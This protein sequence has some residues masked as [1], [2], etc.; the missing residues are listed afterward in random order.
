MRQQLLAFLVSFSVFFSTMLL[1]DELKLKA[2]APSLYLVKSGDTLWD[3][4]GLYLQHPWLWPRLWKL[5]PQVS[6]PHLI[7]PGDELHL[8]FDADG[9]PILSL[10]SQREA[11]SRAGT[12]QV[13]N[14]STT[15]A[16]I[17]L[18]PKVRRMAKADKAIPAVALA[19]ID[20]FLSE[21]HLLAAEQ[22]ESLPYVL[23]GKENV[24]NAVSGHLLYVQGELDQTLR[25]GIYRQGEVYE[26]P[27]SG[28]ILGYEAVLMAEAKVLPP[29]MV[30]EQHISRIEVQKSRREVKQGDRL[31]PLPSQSVYPDFF[32]LQS[33]DTVVSGVIVDSASEWREFAKGE[34][35]LLNQGQNAQLQPGHLLGIFRPS[36]AVVDFGDKPSYPEDSDKLQ[37][38]LHEVAGSA[39]EMPTELVGQLMI[40]KVS[41]HS[42]FA[43][44]LR[45][46]QPVRVGDL[47]GNL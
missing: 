25:Y 5:N 31:I 20:P 30:G 46:E 17:K 3:I 6:N 11:V 39:D 4:A 7:Y 2:D 36:P 42:S 27:Q 32:Q 18:T 34:I 21:E 23:G 24:K 16:A 13:Q 43:M 38:I 19:A 33:P 10:N 37:R 15:S 47:I 28:D 41:E 26:D 29:A 9:Q 45:T 14:Y 12:T 8:Q 35:V 40:V 22:L 44:I 1:A